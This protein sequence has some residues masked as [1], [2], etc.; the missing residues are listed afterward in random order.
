MLH[1]LERERVDC[2]IAVLDNF[3]LYSREDRAMIQEELAG[4]FPSLRIVDIQNRTW[5]ESTITA[6]D[7]IIYIFN[8]ENQGYAK[9]HNLAFAIGNHHFGS[10]V[11]L[12]CGNDVECISSTLFSTLVG[13]LD[14]Q[15]DIGVI[16]PRIISHTATWQG[17]FKYQS[18]YKRYI[19]FLFYPIIHLLFGTYFQSKVI[20]DVI[21]DIEEGYV[22]RLMGCFLLF[23]SSAFQE[24]G[25]FDEDTFL[26]AE[27]QII[28]ERLAQRGYR[29]YYCGEV[30]I[31][32]EPGKTTRAFF[33]E[34]DAAWLRFRNDMVYYRKYKNV[35]AGM[36]ILAT[37]SFAVYLYVY[38]PAAAQLAALVRAVKAPLK[39]VR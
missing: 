34:R 19:A 17:P 24:V 32:H 9:G 36:I 37:F 15:R 28:S 14:K 3:E 7:G 39:P 26:F 6:D 27:E 38:K 35:S 16:G 2:R 5:N 10:D 4:V 13:H 22:Y 29:N 12:A 30:A 25:G 33:H 1:Q 8:N 18:I 31:R 11:F 20:S 21:T 23:R